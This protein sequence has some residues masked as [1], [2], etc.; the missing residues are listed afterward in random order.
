M[1]D[2]LFSLSER[3]SL[4]GFPDQVDLAGFWLKEHDRAD[5]VG[6]RRTDPD[7]LAA[8]LQ[9]GSLRVLGF[10]PSDLTGVPAEAIQTVA[11]QLGLEPSLLDTYDPPERTLRNHIAGVERHLGFRRSDQGDLKAVGDWLVLRALEHDRPITLH[12][13]LC[14]H[15]RAE[16]LV[17]P[18]L[19]TLERLIAHARQ[20]AF[21]ETWIKLRPEL[22]ALQIREI[23]SLLEFDESLGATPLVWLCQ[24]AS[25]PAAEM[26]REQVVKLERL[27]QLG[28]ASATVATLPANRVRHLARL[29]QRHTPQA[30]R[31]F[32][33]E[34]RY[35]IVAC[36]LDRCRDHDHSC[37]RTY[38]AST[39]R[40][41]CFDP[42]RRSR[43]DVE[44]GTVVKVWVC[45]PVLAPLDRVV[46]RRIQG[47]VATRCAWSRVAS[48]SVGVCQPRIL[49]G[50]VLSSS[51]AA[52]RS[53]GV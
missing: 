50:R 24:Q 15:L 45:S 46:L 27:R 14:D 2:E 10:V 53:A 44:V 11:S 42:R 4:D 28:I 31:R 49:R 35:Q 25:A 5:V 17:R 12:G 40:C 1:A 34:H 23:D 16:Q 43:V 19:S 7:R 33:P 30:L 29:G 8:G 38:R 22:T 37:G 47:I 52:L 51:S 41:R 6:W 20:V 36:T 3:N 39:R 9:I 18:A 26:V 13:L 48:R 21:D 32:H